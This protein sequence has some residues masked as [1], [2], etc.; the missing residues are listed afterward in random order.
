[1]PSNGKLWG[2]VAILCS[3]IAIGA[4]L[5]W[6]SRPAR[7]DV[8]GQAAPAPAVAPARSPVERPPM[9]GLPSMPRAPAE[10]REF[11][12]LGAAA[13]EE[14][15]RLIARFHAAKED[16]ERLEVLGEIEVRC[17]G[18]GLLDL[19]R[20]VF[21]RGGYSREVREQ[22]LELLA[23]NVAAEILPVLE[24]ARRAG[25][26]AQRTQA[27]QAAARVRDEKVV[28]FIAGSFGDEEK[29]VRMVAL[30]V[31]RELPH[32]PRE[33]LLVRA[34]HGAR[35]DVALAGLAELEVSATPATLPFLFD[36]LAAPDAGVRDEARDA[37]E[38]LLDE[39]FTDRRAAAA[40]WEA[41]RQRFDENLIRVD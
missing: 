2:Y 13:R 3:G 4:L 33:R 18:R 39:T 27:L 7:S 23:G 26:E 16:R 20:Q 30:D 6:I 35:R 12:A 34:M 22:V 40:W 21:E 10:A 17:Y 24:L 37:L 9:A 36:G 41:N 19:A 38:F 25:D 29:N 1:M 31:A 14:L 28:D 8:T 32:G 11:T 15:T 5:T